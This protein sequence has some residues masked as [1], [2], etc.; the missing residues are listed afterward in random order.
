MN[1]KNKYLL[2]LKEYGKIVVLFFLLFEGATSFAV[3]SSSLTSG[4]VLPIKNYTQPKVFPPIKL[5]WPTLSA[6]SFEKSIFSKTVKPDQVKQSNPKLF[7]LETRP[8]QLHYVEA[9]ELMKFLEKNDFGLLSS[10]GKVEIDEAE[11]ILWVHDHTNFIENL[12]NIIQQYDKPTPQI[13]I[14]AKIINIDSDYLHSIGVAFTNQTLTQGEGGFDNII[15]PIARLGHDVLLEATLDA[16]EKRGHAHLISDPQL[17]TL[18]R[19]PAT[20]EAGEEVPYQESTYSGGTTVS[21]KKAVLRLEVTPVVMP[22]NRI[23]LHLKINQDQVGALTV[24]G[25]PAINT[26]QISTQAYVKNQSTL[27]LGGIFEKDDSS[28]NG[29]VP[30]MSRIPVVGNLFN[31]K[32]RSDNRKQLLI[33]VTPIIVQGA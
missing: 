31:H 12:K 13:Y 17:I 22:N 16:L 1:I 23:L 24:S 30:G 10:Q 4:L 2:F 18:D 29:K 7:S 27:V 14:K 5:T 33:F 15:V 25:V 9:K 21:F 11:N 8:I 6:F 26:Q 28:Q 20:I 3:D 32:V 19:Q